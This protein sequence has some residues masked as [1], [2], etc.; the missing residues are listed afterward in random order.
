MEDKDLLQ[1]QALGITEAKF[2][3]QIE[4]LKTGFPHLEV[5]SAATP[6]KGIVVLSESQQAKAMA[7]SEASDA[8]VSKFVPA[9]GAASRMFKDLFNGLAKIEKGEALSEESPAKKFCSHIADFA[10]A[11]AADFAKKS[12]REVLSTTLNDA[13]LGYGSKSKGQILFHNY[14]DGP[15][16]AFEEH[17]VEGAEYA[18]SA[19][20]KVNIIFS[21]SKEHRAAYQALFDAVKEKYETAFGV[22]YNVSFTL[23]L[24]S[25]DTIAVDETNE[26]FRKDDGNLL[27]RPGGHGALI[28]NVNQIVSDVIIIK[29]IDNVVHQSRIEDTVRWKK[30]LVGRLLQLSE[31]SYNYLHRIEEGDRESE[32]I[33]EMIDFLDKEFCVTLPPEAFSL[34][35]QKML[36]AIHAKLNRPMRVCGMVRNEGEPGGGPFIVKDA[37][38]A[39]SLQ[40]LESVQLDNSDP[41]IA[42]LFAAGTH[43]NPVDLV[44][45]PINYKG[46]KFD[47]LRYVDLKAGFISSKSYEGRALKALELPGL[48]NGAMS[49][50]NT[51]FVDVPLSTF[52]P[53]KTVLDLLRPEHHQK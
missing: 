26:P 4:S 14:S 22:K 1:L 11:G 36:E 43:F 18:R 15:R 23:Q 48:W 10:F 5:I 17:L 30:L 3:S 24:P 31:R 44:C 6:Q 12:D 51:Q 8:K 46:K 21:V 2:K 13:G 42:G 16:T 27:F 20:G 45:N 28:E 50:W 29:N 52:N 25:T 37:D 32:F 38:G 49:N 40:I 47:L 35:K 33:W 41:S 7:V 53:V 34:S 19:D 9:S 39:S